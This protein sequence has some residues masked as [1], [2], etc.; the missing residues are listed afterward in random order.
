MKN[1]LLLILFLFAFYTSFS[2]NKYLLKGF[3]VKHPVVMCIT[4][5]DDT[6]FSARYFYNNNLQDIFLEGKPNSNSTKL[7]FTKSAWNYKL[8]QDTLCERMSLSTQNKKNWLGSWTNGRYNLGVRLTNIDTTKIKLPTPREHFLDEGLDIYYSYIRESKIALKKDS[9]S[10]LSQ[11]TLQWY[12]EKTSGIKLF[13]V[14]AGIINTT[15]LNKVNK[16]LHEFQMNQIV[17]F[18]DCPSNNRRSG[19]Y[20]FYLNSIYTTNNFLSIDA[21]SY[22]D[23]GGVHPN[24]SNDYLNINLQTGNTIDK[25]SDVFNLYDSSFHTI[26]EDSDDTT[27]SSQSINETIFVDYENADTTSYSVYKIMQTLYKKEMQVDD[28]LHD[29]ECRFDDYNRW[30]FFDFVF[31]YDGVY[32]NPH[33]PHVIQSCSYPEWSVIP[34]SILKKYLKKES[35]FVL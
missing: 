7:V 19:E 27:I 16:T 15:I 10:K 8:K 28:S 12:K 24:V 25:I 35:Q 5:D 9:V 6:T 32:F 26:K 3:I 23:C 21:A 22:Y 17:A 4:Q 29:Y 20:N 33:F 34:Y 13:R 1:H 30:Q 11:L 31:R 18:F 14:T 2:Q